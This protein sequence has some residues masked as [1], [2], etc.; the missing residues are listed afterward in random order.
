MVN[1]R[2]RRNPPTAEEITILKAGP[3]KVFFTLIDIYQY[4]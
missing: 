1:M 3:L 4:V 2:K